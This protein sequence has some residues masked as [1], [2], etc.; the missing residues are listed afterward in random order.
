MT[1]LN[2]EKFISTTELKNN[3]KTV[4]EKV[5]NY[6]EIFIM[7]N[8]KPSVV[9]MSIEQYNEINNFRIVWDIIPMSKFDEKNLIRWMENY[10]NWNTISEEELFEGLLD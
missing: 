1:I 6:W 10:R 4:I 5:N 9:I 7:N 3:T 2:T 8:N